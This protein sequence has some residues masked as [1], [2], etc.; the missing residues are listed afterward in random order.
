MMTMTNPITPPL[1]LLDLVS[2]GAEAEIAKKILQ[3][4][5]PILR[6]QGAD[7][8]LEACCAWLREF[9]PGGTEQLRCSRRPKPPSLKE[10]AIAALSEMSIEPCL[11][12]D[13]D[14]NAAV[15]AKYN[16]IRRALEALDD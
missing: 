10:Q 13:V 16:T 1:E 6:Q 12:N 3:W 2:S 9:H 4:A 8:E 7:Q 14:V 15:C 11:I 5:A